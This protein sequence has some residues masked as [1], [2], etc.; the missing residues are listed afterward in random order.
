MVIWKNGQIPVEQVKKNAI[1]GVLFK[2][3]AGAKGCT[4]QKPLIKNNATQYD[5]ADFFDLFF[6]KDAAY[7][8]YATVAADTP[9]IIKVNKKEYKVGYVISVMKDQLRKDLEEAGIIKSLS[10]GF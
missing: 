1:H 5:K 4:A 7:L 6:G 3:F 9:E 10:S 8:K 2:G